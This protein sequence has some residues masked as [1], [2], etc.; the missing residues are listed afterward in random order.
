MIFK[1]YHL[2]FIIWLS[3]Y[4]FTAILPAIAVAVIAT[5][6]L[7]LFVT[8]LWFSGAAT[9]TCAETLRQEGFTGR[10]LVITKENNLPYDRPKLSKVNT[11][12]VV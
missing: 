8:K 3:H 2:L 7:L 11:D 10:I 12:F 1:L 5:T 9:A 4:N 6:A